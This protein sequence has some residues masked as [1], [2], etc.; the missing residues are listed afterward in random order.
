MQQPAHPNGETSGH[1]SKSDIPIAI[2]TRPLQCFVRV[3]R[4]EWAMTENGSP[5]VKWR[6]PAAAV[7]ALTMAFLAKQADAQ[8]Y[9]YSHPPEAPTAGAFPVPQQLQGHHFIGPLINSV[10]IR[11]WSAEPSAPDVPVGGVHGWQDFTSFIPLMVQPNH[12]DLLFHQ[13]DFRSFS[14]GGAQPAMKPENIPSGVYVQFDAHPVCQIATVQFP[15][16]GH[17]PPMFGPLKQGLKVSGRF[18]SEPSMDE[19]YFFM[20]V[21]LVLK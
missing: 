10:G 15:T 13:T 5:R 6:L 18:L 9:I 16:M 1:H 14:G 11:C 20:A 12:L 4:G 8:Q 17:F 2:T 19:C 21:W 3:K 7:C